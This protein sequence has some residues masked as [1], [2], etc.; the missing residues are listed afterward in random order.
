MDMKAVVWMAAAV[1]CAW[2]QPVAVQQAQIT[3]ESQEA[4]RC[5]GEVEVDGAAEI[6]IE[7]A[8]GRMRTVSGNEAGWRRLECTSALPMS[9][10]E[11][12]FEARD[13]RG[14][15]YLIRAPRENAGVALIRVEDPKNGS[16]VYTFGF[17][18]TGSGGLI[19]SSGSLGSS[20]A[21]EGWMRQIRF[22]SKGDGYLHTFG[23]GSDMLLDAVSIAVEPGGRVVAE[24]QTNQRDPLRLTGRLVHAES[25][26]LVAAM[27]RGVIGT[28]EMSIDRKDRVTAITMSGAGRNR[29]DLRWQPSSARR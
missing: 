5:T 27:D 14:T 3:G 1:A 9:A 11:F 10:R 17:T 6:A 28:L 18:W 26:R 15:Q 8:Q 25:G 2:A 4:G 20:P 13:G 22:Q 24:F 29:F 23:R 12:R 21:P 16:G 19:S 7:G